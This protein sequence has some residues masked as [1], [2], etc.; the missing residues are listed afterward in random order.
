MQMPIASDC[1]QRSMCG[2]QI[3]KK[4]KDV[5]W[6]SNTI[7]PGTPFMHRVSVALQYY[8]HQRLNNDPGWR[9]ITVRAL[10]T[11]SR[12][13]PDSQNAMVLLRRLSTACKGS[14]SEPFNQPC[15]HTKYLESAEVCC[16][17]SPSLVLQWQAMRSDFITRRI[18]SLY[19]FLSLTAGFTWCAGDPIR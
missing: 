5:M 17:V 12:T 3:P 8:I 6:D 15:R 2:M 18:Y 9:G 11:P 1:H 10:S 7:T 4:E 19:R 13:K 16:G 14:T